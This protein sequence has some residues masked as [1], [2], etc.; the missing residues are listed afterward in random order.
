MAN[1]EC[2]SV[3]SEIRAWQSVKISRR[4]RRAYFRYPLPAKRVFFF[5]VCKFWREKKIISSS[6]GGIYLRYKKGFFAIFLG[7]TLARCESMFAANYSANITNGFRIAARCGTERRR[8]G[9]RCGI[10]F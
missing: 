10:V 3:L 8:E 6:R 5:R 4:I 1:G 7:P 2:R 9:V